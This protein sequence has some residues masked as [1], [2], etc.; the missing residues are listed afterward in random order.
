VLDK[1]EAKKFAIDALKKLGSTD[2]FSEETF[3][4]IFSTFD[5]NNSGTAEK[6]EMA[7]FIKSFQGGK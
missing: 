4:Q 5:T 6:N 7:L 1:E 2:N 3:D